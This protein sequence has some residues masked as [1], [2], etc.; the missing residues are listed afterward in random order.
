MIA[1]FFA[2][3]FG[4]CYHNYSQWVINKTFVAEKSGD[5]K[6]LQTR[7]CSKCGYTDSKMTTYI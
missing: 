1:R 5:V 2:Y 3:L 4:Y 7:C 6:I